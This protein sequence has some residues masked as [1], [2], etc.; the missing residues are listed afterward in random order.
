MTNLKWVDTI[1]TYHEL[2][3]VIKG[4]ENSP[5]DALQMAEKI[6]KSDLLCWLEKIH[7]GEAP[8]FFRVE[9]MC[10]RDSFYPDRHR[11]YHIKA[12]CGHPVRSGYGALRRLGGRCADENH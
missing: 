2:L 7:A 5:M 9:K 6:V 3:F 1:R 8:Y 10:I 11:G 4:M 12:C